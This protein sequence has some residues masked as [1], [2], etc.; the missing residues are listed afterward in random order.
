MTAQH[1][2]IVQP[3][4]IAY[5]HCF[6]GIAGDMALGALL[7]AGAD[8]GEV[9]AM[10]KGL[11]VPGWSLDTERVS[12]RGIAATRA[13]VGV[14]DDAVARNHSV[15]ADLIGSAPLPGRVRDRALAVFRT[16]A[17]AEGAVHGTSPDDVHFHEVGGHDAIVD[18]VGTCAALETLGVDEVRAAPIPVGRGFIR[19]RHGLI[20]NPGP[21]VVELVARARAPIQG[22]D[23]EAEMATP[24]GAALLVTLAARFGAMPSMTVTGNGFGAGTK[25]F[26]EFPNVTQVVLG[27][28]T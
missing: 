11:D 13:I 10:L 9:R 26:G 18:I 4:K 5:F 12:R 22:H 16:L 19:C 17:E 21:A 15:I 6:A 27:E 25:V 20:P 8:L 23:V 7:D 14:E 2:Q 24:T 3:R 28:T 1:K